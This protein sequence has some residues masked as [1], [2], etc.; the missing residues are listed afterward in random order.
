MNGKRK[1]RRQEETYDPH[2][3]LVCVHE[4]LTVDL[5]RCEEHNEN[6]RDVGVPEEFDKQVR[7]LWPPAD[8]I[9]AD[10][11][12]DESPVEAGEGKVVCKHNPEGDVVEELADLEGVCGGRQLV[13]VGRG[14]HR[15]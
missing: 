8:A 2:D 4:G 7:K 15:S 10:E 11:A 12:L 1:G 5:G 9:A 14:H 6:G 3:T 13:P